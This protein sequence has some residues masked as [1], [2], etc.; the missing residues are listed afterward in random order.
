MRIIFKE[1]HKMKMKIQKLIGL[2]LL[3]L[4][5]L[6]IAIA[7]AFDEGDVTFVMITIPLGIWLI[8]SKKRLLDTDQNDE[9]FF[10]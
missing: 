10:K 3:L 6:V 7:V 4:S 1:V 2:G 9:E 5:A 8:V